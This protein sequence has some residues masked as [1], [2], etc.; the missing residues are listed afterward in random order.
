[1]MFSPVWECNINNVEGFK[2]QQVESSQVSLFSLWKNTRQRSK[3][4][5]KQYNIK[6]TVKH[7]TTTMIRASATMHYHIITNKWLSP[8]W[9][10]CCFCRCCCCSWLSSKWHQAQTEI[11]QILVPGKCAASEGLDLTPPIMQLDSIFVTPFLPG[12][13]LH[14]SN[15]ALVVFSPPKFSSKQRL[16]DFRNPPSLTGDFVQLCV[17]FFFLFTGSLLIL[18]TSK[19][20]SMCTIC[21]VAL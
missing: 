20:I 15:Y 8:C 4:R 17:C 11:S 10:C 5:K 21:G 3:K 19:L 18:K 7:N 16:K 1:M 12:K 14:V 2:L 9:C 13:C 6:Q